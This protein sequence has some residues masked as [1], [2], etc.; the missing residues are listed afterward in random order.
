VAPAA[1]VTPQDLAGRGFRRD[2]AAGLLTQNLV[3]PPAISLPT[4]PVTNSPPAKRAWRV[5]SAA[6]AHFRTLQQA[7]EVAQPGDTVVA[8]AGEHGGFKT[9]RSG[10]KDEPITFRGEPGAV[11]NISGNTPADHVLVRGTDWIV[12]TG[13][14]VRDAP[15]AG[16]SVIDAS[17]VV[18]SHNVVGPNGVWAIFTGFAP[19]VQILHNKAFG[20]RREHGIYVSNSRGPDDNPVVRGN[21]CYANTASGIQFNGDCQAGGDGVIQGALI[22]NNILHDN[23][24]KAFSLI[25]IEDS[26]IQ[27]NLIY[28][29]GRTSGAA[30]IHLT[31]ELGCG[32]P[33]RRNVVANNT[34]V[35]P[36][37]AGIRLTDRAG[38]NVIFNNLLVGR[39][40][41]DEAGGN[42]VDA[43]SNVLI[44]SPAKVFANP[45]LGDYRLKP[46]FTPS[47]GTSTF[48]GRMAPTNDISGAA[49]AGF[50]P[51][52]GACDVHCLPL[53]LPG[54]FDPRSEALWN[55]I[56]LSPP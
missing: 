21:E 40:I 3:T 30:G 17:D 56:P 18:V 9:V 42:Q 16:I 23:E 8:Q 46:M 19:R 20:S 37:I 4:S 6:N 25:S 36:R 28:N 38:E 35:E 27:N 31:D 51:A 49:R 15:R 50:A 41:V 45:E 5:G 1:P 55:A 26:V 33:S 32:K 12:I 47:S 13:F 14:T 22:E 29:N 7:A 43:R 54:M 24:S 2:P 10:R 44:D 34:I 39:A 48:G 11:I 52:V 53:P